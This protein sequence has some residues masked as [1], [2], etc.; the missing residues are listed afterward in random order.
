MGQLAARTIV[1]RI[2]EDEAETKQLVVEP[3]LVV[4][5]STAR[6]P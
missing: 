5:H 3:A 4:R 2:I 6:F 1:R